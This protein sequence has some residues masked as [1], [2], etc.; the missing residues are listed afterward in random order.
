MT[1][2]RHSDSSR[3]C[4]AVFKAAKAGRKRA[5][6][7]SLALDT[8]LAAFLKWQPPRICMPWRNWSL[9]WTV[10]LLLS[11]L[12]SLCFYLQER[13]IIFLLLKKEMSVG[14]I[15]LHFLIR[16]QPGA[17]RTMTFLGHYK[18]S[19]VPWCH[20]RRTFYSF[21]L[22]RSTVRP[23]CLFKMTNREQGGRCS[24]Y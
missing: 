5:E 12:S 1:H 13:Y 8:I 6:R 16:L 7:I 11:N 24:I 20:F 14:E 15:A 21:V 22:Q 23:I 3:I 2:R 10:M 9:F 18:L 17:L 19:D 4:S